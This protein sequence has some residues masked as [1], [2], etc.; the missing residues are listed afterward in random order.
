MMALNSYMPKMVAKPV[1]LPVSEETE[2]SSDIALIKAFNQRL[3]KK[4]NRLLFELENLEDHNQGISF[5]Q[6]DMQGLIYIKNKALEDLRKVSKSLDDTITKLSKLSRNMENQKELEDSKINE[7]QHVTFLMDYQYQLIEKYSEYWLSEMTQL[8]KERYIDLY[9]M[10]YK[11]PREIAKTQIE[12]LVETNTKVTSYNT[13]RL[14][15]I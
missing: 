2:T 12:T 14:S 6:N 15:K 10:A 7:Q 8:E 13:K 9:V 4:C 1:E 11:I 5:I 3:D